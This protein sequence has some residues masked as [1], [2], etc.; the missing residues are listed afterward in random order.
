VLGGLD[1]DGGSVVSSVLKFDS[2][3]GTWSQVEPMP[4]PRG[5]HAACAIRS[6]VYVFGGRCDIGGHIC[7]VLKYDTETN[8]WS[9]LEPMPFLCFRHSVSVLDG[10]QVY[11]IGAGPDG[12]GVLRFDTASSVWGTLS[13][14]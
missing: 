5:L 3:Q 14:T 9:T 2:T 7:S 6:D 11:V 8:I 4:E 13:V 10:D 1:S 12:K